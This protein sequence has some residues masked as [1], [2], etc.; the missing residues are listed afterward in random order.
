MTQPNTID[1]ALTSA[2]A[3][4]TDANPKSLARH[5]AAEAVMPGGNTRTTLYHAPF[6]LGIERGTG[7]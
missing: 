6:P 2:Y 7:C 1:S 4:Y 5:I 3:N